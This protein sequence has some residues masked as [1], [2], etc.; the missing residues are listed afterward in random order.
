MVGKIGAGEAPRGGAVGVSEAPDATPAVTPAIDGSPGAIRRMVVRLAWP[1]ILENMLHSVFGVILLLL[2]ARLG[3][4]AV[5]G[6]GAANGLLMVAMAAFFA[7]SMGATVLV[8]HA[9]GARTPAAAGL[10][11]KQS[12]VL[13]VGVGLVMTVIGVLFAP[14]LVAAMGAG[15]DVVLEGAAFMRAFSLGSVFLVTTFIAGG[16]LRGAGDAR[17]PMLVTLGTIILSLLLAVP[18]TFGG[19]GLPGL[20]LTGA[21]LASTLSR[22]AGCVVLLAFLARPG[23]PI[24]LAGRAGWRPAREPIQRLV[25]IGLPSMIESIFRAGGMLFFT[26]IVFRLGTEIVA[27]QQIAQQA[28]FLSMMPGFGFS[29]AATALVGQGLGARDPERAERASGFATRACLL[30]MGLMGV[31]FFIG[32]PWIMR[33]F[34][35]DPTIIEQ[36]ALALRVV[37]LAQP[38]QAVGMVLAGALRGAGDTQYPMITTGVTMWLVRLPVAWLLGITLGFGLAG[39]YLG[40]VLDSVVLSLLNWRRYKAGEW[41]T[42]QLVKS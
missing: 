20:G 14:Q 7:L 39:V 16:V 30:W 5:A 36:G 38:G 29:M 40:W 3:P 1:S 28:A 11:A 27:A 32:G 42:R 17:T 2:V 12:L 6:F 25:S 8:A 31:V 24:P 22:A 10:A 21:G 26:V 23:G 13:G 4:A 9:T 19:L 34:T 37:A 18:L 33:A 15:P 35:D 41:K